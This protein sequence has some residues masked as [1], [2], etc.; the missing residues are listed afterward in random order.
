KAKLL[1]L[2]WGVTNSDKTESEHRVECR[3][4]AFR[5]HWRAERLTRRWLSLPGLLKAVKSNRGRKLSYS[6]FL[7]KGNFLALSAL[8]NGFVRE[9]C[10]L[11]DAVGDLRKFALVRKNGW[12]ILWLANQ[13][14]RTQ[15]LPYL[16]RPRI[17][18]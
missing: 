13:I 12:Q 6:Y 17:D 11:P 4:I 5:S 1:I 10:L 18:D 15:C 14:K 2:G 3:L 8:A 16:L 7:F 9:H